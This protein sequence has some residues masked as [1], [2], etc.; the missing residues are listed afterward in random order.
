MREARRPPRLSLL[1]PRGFA[2]DQELRLPGQVVRYERKARGLVSLSVRFDGLEQEPSWLVSKV[3]AVRGDYARRLQAQRD[4]LSDICRAPGWSCDFHR[5]DQPPPAALLLV[6]APAAHVV[7]TRRASRPVRCC[8][9]A[10]AVAARRV[11]ALGA[12]VSYYVAAFLEGEVDLA[13][14]QARFRSPPPASRPPDGPSRSA[15]VR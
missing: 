13:E 11:C 10:P 2:G 8:P 6:A 1:L 14:L 12:A 3:E 9:P 5:S 7:P 4:G 15:H